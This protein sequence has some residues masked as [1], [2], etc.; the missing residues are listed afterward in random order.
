MENLPKELQKMI[1]EYAAELKPYNMTSKDF[2]TS[3]ENIAAYVFLIIDNCYSEFYEIRNTR[4]FTTYL[5]SLIDELHRDITVRA[6]RIEKVDIRWRIASFDNLFRLG[7]PWW[8]F[9]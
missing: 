1:L 2:A 4:W 7:M 8:G 3:R 5:G 6:Y 9:L